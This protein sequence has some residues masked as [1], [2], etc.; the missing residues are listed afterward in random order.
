MVFLKEIFEKVDFEINYPVAAFFEFF[1][2]ITRV[3]ELYIRKCTLWLSLVGQASQLFNHFLQE[4][5]YA[6]LHPLNNY[7]KKTLTF[8]HWTKKIPGHLVQSVTCLSADTCLTADPGVPSSIT[9]WSHT[10]VEIGHE[11]ISTAVLLPYADLR[12]VVVSYKRKY[13]HKVLVNCL[14]KLVELVNWPSPY[15]HSCW[16]RR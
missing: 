3:S 14:V 6:K 11:I 13:V 16:L 12:R 10:F 2:Y 8:V 15:D 9:A 1:S 7:I 4:Y 5:I